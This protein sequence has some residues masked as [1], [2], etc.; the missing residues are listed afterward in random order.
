MGET[1]DCYH[2][3][4]SVEKRKTMRAEHDDTGKVV[5]ICPYCVYA[6][7]DGEEVSEDM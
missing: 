7:S 1:I 4:D 6:Q 2:C 3:G 5:R